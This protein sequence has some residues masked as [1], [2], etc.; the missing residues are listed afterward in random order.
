VKAHDNS[1]AY[2][3]F[4][5]KYISKLFTDVD[6]NFLLAAKK[7]FRYVFLE[8]PSS[9]K[10][11]L[12]NGKEILKRFKVFIKILCFINIIGAWFYK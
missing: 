10:S 3:P 8:L 1:T 12:S 5:T 9:Q 4:I 2:Q 11:S 6:R 7:L